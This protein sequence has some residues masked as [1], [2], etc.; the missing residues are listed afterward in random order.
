MSLG[1]KPVKVLA[2]WLCIILVASESS[3]ATSSTSSEPQGRKKGGKAEQTE[4]AE[5][6]KTTPPPQTR[7]SV[8][9]RLNLKFRILKRTNDGHAEEANPDSIFKQNDRIQIAVTPSRPGYLYIIQSESDREGELIFPHSG[10]G[11]QNKITN[12]RDEYTVPPAD[13]DKKYKDDGGKCWLPISSTTGRILITVYFSPSSTD[14]PFTIQ[15]GGKISQ[16]DL[17][18]TRNLASKETDFGTYGRQVV[19]LRNSKAV[20]ANIELN[21]ELAKSGDPA[22]AANKTSTP[23]PHTPTSGTGS[24]RPTGSAV[25]STP[26]KPEPGILWGRLQAEFDSQASNGVRVMLLKETA[27][28]RIPASPLEEFKQG[29]QLSLEFYT[30]FDG[31]V[32]VVHMS[33]LGRST[34]VLPDTKD[35]KKIRANIRSLAIMKRLDLRINEKGI[36]TLQVVLSANRIPTFDEAIEKRGGSLNVVVAGPQPSKEPGFDCASSLNLLQAARHQMSIASEAGDRGALAVVLSD[37]VGNQPL[38]GP[39]LCSSLNPGQIKGDRVKGQEVAVF[40]IRFKE[41]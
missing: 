19:A 40:E 17:V 12:T 16:Q 33:P 8:P 30:N 41:I 5:T 11:D 3:A 7:H 21:H 24:S 37:K 26:P 6:G 1:F 18:N 13:C 23:D 31:Y 9:P 34:V 2:I 27:N 28:G 35:I 36:H 10:I 15:S 25:N 32:Y 22:V 4:N 29:D 14:L 38:P 39:D 20:A